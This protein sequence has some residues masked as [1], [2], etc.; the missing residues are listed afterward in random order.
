MT[1]KFGKL[2]LFEINPLSSIEIL[3]LFYVSSVIIISMMP[4]GNLISKAIGFIFIFYFI[5]V[6][7]FWTKAKL[8]L[9]KE[10]I[11]IVIW[12][13]FCILSGM[14]AKDIE[15]VSIKILTILQLV[16]FFIAGYSVVLQ[17]NISERQ[18]FYTF[19]FSMLI[20]ILYGI[21]TYEPI[22]GFAYKNRIASTTGNPNNLAAYGSFA[23]IFCLY[24]I[25]IEK[26][27]LIRFIAIIF[28]IAVAY[29]ILK[30]LSRQGIIMMVGGTAIYCTIRIIYNF[31]NSANRGKH[32]FKLFIITLGIIGIIAI[33]LKYLS[34][35]HYYFRIKT[36]LSFAQM[37]ISSSTVNLAKIV[38][39]SAYERSQFIIYGIK[40]WL[41]NLLF[42]VGLDNFRVTIRQYWPISNSTYSHN[43]YI[44][45]LSTIG[46][47][48]SIA[49]YAIYYSVFNRLLKI[50]KT[51]KL[52]A[53]QINLI[54]IFY[55]ALCTL[56]LVELVTVSYSKK[57]TW[58]LLVIII[59]LSDRIVPQKENRLIE[60]T[61]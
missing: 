28:T 3:F 56:L 31:R 54:H 58:I 47:I 51:F 17:G 50:R 35:S 59:G 52:S 39:Y 61:N 46:T 18:I 12:I 7:I 13:F 37:G 19:I 25:S 26:N 43:N 5:V 20:V 9:S 38:D 40:I 27:K 42:G 34:D 23:Y 30:T 44:E 21:G 8:Y 55:T 29:G 24:L 1:F 32:F 2:K 16:I 60:N 15:L 48:G 22:S 33:S 41:D 57:F 6:Y 53:R 36:L 49:Y 11:Y 4:I 45:L 10:F 14:F